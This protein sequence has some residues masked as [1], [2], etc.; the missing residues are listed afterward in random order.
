MAIDPACVG[1]TTKT[2][3][4]DVDWRTLAT[5]ALGIGAKRDELEFLYEGA[6][7]GMKTYPT[8]AVVP[9]YG[10]LVESLAATGGDMAMVVHG[11]QIVRVIG[12]LPGVGN[13]DELRLETTGRIAGL[14]DLKKFA[15]AVITTETR[16]EGKPIYET[17]WSIIY[18]GAGGF[19]GP[20]PLEWEGPSL[21][22]DR[23]A[24]FAAAEKTSP[25][26]ALLYR[27]SGDQNPL[28]ADPA[29]AE[30]V[31]FAQGPILHGLATFGF[32]GRAVVR[33]ACGGDPSR[34]RAIGAQFRK[35]VWPGDTLE[36]KGY[37]LEGDRFAIGMNV[38]ERNEAV[39][40]GAFADVRAAS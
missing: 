5:Y 11:A 39:L 27:I 13:G 34:L 24:D 7:G 6:P 12:E 22:K 29:F 31:G 35:P 15:Q 37:R 3:H 18:R 33:H 23:A 10:P 25:E 4:L 40:G 16:L 26:Q 30:R 32:M 20:R 14:Y 28:H 17:T 2:H 36:T 38:V 1:R 19:G 21:P 8:F 9:T